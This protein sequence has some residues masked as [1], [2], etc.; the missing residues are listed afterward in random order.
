MFLNFIYTI[1]TSYIG[2]YSLISKSPV[3]THACDTLAEI[4]AHT[5]C[6]KVLKHNRPHHMGIAQKNDR[7]IFEH[8]AY[9]LQG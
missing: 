4:S 3:A 5:A 8:T 2:H 7:Q 9:P 1:L 6:A